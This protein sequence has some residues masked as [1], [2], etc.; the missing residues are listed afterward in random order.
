VTIGR[1]YFCCSIV[2]LA[3]SVVVAKLPF[4]IEQWSKIST[5][6]QEFPIVNGWVLT[7]E[8]LATSEMTTDVV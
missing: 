7:R 5:A 4:E 2:G 1:R 8:D 3:V 6:D